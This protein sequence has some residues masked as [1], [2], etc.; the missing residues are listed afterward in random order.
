RR[1]L[2]NARQGRG[3][4]HK[5]S[6]SLAAVAS[7]PH[8]FRI[9]R[10]MMASISAK[11]LA[12]RMSRYKGFATRRAALGM[13]E[14]TESARE[15]CSLP[16]FRGGV[17]AREARHTTL[18]RDCTSGDKRLSQTPFPGLPLSPTL[19]RKEGASPPF[20]GRECGH[21]YS[22]VSSS[23]HSSPR[24]QHEIAPP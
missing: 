24:K 3:D 21:N 6:F 20:V 23:V 18:S 19:P 5:D 11:P 9:R 2:R 17:G 13:R 12:F 14:F 8:R 22:R 1:G 16:P 10:H 4:A 7:P 15:V